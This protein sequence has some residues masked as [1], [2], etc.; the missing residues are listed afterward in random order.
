[1]NLDIIYHQKFNRYNFFEI[2]RDTMK[3]LMNQSN[4]KFKNM[5]NKT[6]LLDLY[7]IKF[8]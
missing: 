5:T 7:N 4:K 6:F 1:M 8:L 3:Q 2:E